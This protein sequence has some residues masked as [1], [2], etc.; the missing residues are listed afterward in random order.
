MLMEKRVRPGRSCAMRALREG[1][2]SMS[3]G[4]SDTEVTEL[5]VIACTR[6]STSATMIVTP[7][8]NSPTTSRNCLE[9]KLSSPWL[10]R[11]GRRAGKC[12]DASGQFTHPH[13]H[14][15]GLQV[16][17]RIGRTAYTATGMQA[18]LS[19]GRIVRMQAFRNRDARH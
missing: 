6:P 10:Q 12:D 2:N 3:R 17:H 7:V 19:Q 15:S 8:A 4:S 1:Q 14:S 11:W 9:S 18:Q 13:P 5:A 16:D